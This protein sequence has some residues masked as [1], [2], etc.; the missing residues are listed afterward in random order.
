MTTMTVSIPDH[1]KAWVERQVSSG[2][3]AHASDYL[4]HLI[5]RDQERE[6][7]MAHIQTLVTEGI[8]SGVGRRSMG[9]L[10]TAARS[11]ARASRKPSR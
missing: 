11:Q 4:R 7:K 1:M 9:A 5:R 3:Y 2:H 10:M 8:E 6:A